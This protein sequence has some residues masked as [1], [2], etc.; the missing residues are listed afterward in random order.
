[1]QLG[2]S[3]DEASRLF[4]RFDSDG[5]GTVSLVEFR[6]AIAACTMADAP[7]RQQEAW[8]RDL[9][10][11]IRQAIE[12]RKDISVETVFRKLA[13]E[14][15]RG[16]GSGIDRPSLNKLL[17]TFR[18]DLTDA[19][20][21]Q[22][23]LMIDK[24]RSGLLSFAEFADVFGCAR[25]LAAGGAGAQPM[26]DESFAILV[27]RLLRR[28]RGKG[29]QTIEQ[30]IELFD[31]NRDGRLERKELE[32]ALILEA[33]NLSQYE[34]AQFA[35]RLDTD[36][37]GVIS[38]AELKQAFEAF[39]DVLK[40]V[41]TQAELRA[42][43]LFA[44][45]RNATSRSPHSPQDIF[46]TLCKG[47]R[48][49][50]RADFQ[51]L[52]TT[53]APDLDSAS[54]Q[55]MWQMVDKN[56]DGCLVYEE[57]ARY[58]APQAAHVVAASDE[59]FGILAGRWLR[60]LKASN[61]QTIEAIIRNYDLDGDGRLTTT[62]LEAAMAQHAPNL[63]VAE[64]AE[65]AKRVDSNKDGVITTQELETALAQGESV[66]ANAEKR[67]QEIFVRI[68]SSIARGGHSLPQL[69]KSLCKSSPEKM[70]QQEFYQLL[71]TFEK[72][73]DLASLQLAWQ[74]V[75]KNN[76]GALVYD[77]F[78]QVFSQVAPAFVDVGTGVLTEEYF[79]I[80]SGRWLKKLKAAGF[81]TMEAVMKRLDQDGDG[82]VSC[83][84]LELAMAKDAPNLSQNERFQFADRVDADR[85]GVI[86]TSDLLNALTLGESVY[87]QAEQRA[88]ALFGRLRAAMAGSPHPL[89]QI[90]TSLCKSRAGMMSQAE[91][92]DFVVAFDRT[93]AGDSTSLLLMWQL[94]DKNNDGALVYQEF[95]QHFSQQPV[96]QQPLVTVH[97]VAT[98]ALATS[99]AAP[100]SDE[101][102]GVIAGKLLRRMK[103]LGIQTVEMAAQRF[104]QDRDGLLTPKELEAALERDA[105]A[106]SQF[107]R[108]QFAARVD[109]DRN[110]V[111][112]TK[113]LEAAF[114]RGDVDLGRAE[115]KAAD[116]FT[117]IRDAISRSGH[118]LPQLFTNLCK[119]R[120]GMMLQQEFTELVAAFDPG[121]D[122]A[123]LVLLWQ[124]V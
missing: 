35:A 71:T 25:S 55:L 62:E 37:D 72:F 28:L 16:G 42:Q 41:S 93:M 23:W 4:S 90:F 19:H 81:T 95:A 52:V 27:G 9:I 105:P 111:I 64:R 79:G 36:N 113:E 33:P 60:R 7:Q 59:Y 24:D 50:R 11:G 97:G 86:S 53:F 18:E 1:M 87:S 80:V 22:V 73:L 99:A 65:F 106:L 109:D 88:A 85:D 120:Q 122:A 5:D 10:D 15:G 104:D 91:F 77:E 124:F 48:V 115:R 47:L 3:D 76:D 63:S 67:A 69:F 54:V 75:D 39:G 40:G 84:E 21:E 30:V 2:I 17:R 68:R 13:Q 83:R 108:A 8:M 96:V 118:Q 110:G 49:M 101:Y 89:P 94:L 45:I 100:M 61:F 43:E 78:A 38:V 56:S 57:Y 123:S 26:T 34:R 14:S 66:Y 70:Y 29:V 107:E 51:D 121:V 92:N 58:F 102:F 82:R 20:V 44:R 74:T 103:A 46:A 12:R 98:P 119:T 117:R 31:R 32:T 116:L 6:A 114:R 112:T